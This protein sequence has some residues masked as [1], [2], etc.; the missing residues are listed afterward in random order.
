MKKLLW[1]STATNT[2]T[3]EEAFKLY[4]STTGSLATATKT[5][6]TGTTS[7]WP[8]TTAVGSGGPIYTATMTSG[9]IF[10]YWG[11]IRSS[12]AMRAMRE[13][14]IDCSVLSLSRRH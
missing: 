12:K 6:T 1:P 8:T 2:S 3:F 10:P 5:F 9:P 13:A 7:F 14:I 4:T 11:L